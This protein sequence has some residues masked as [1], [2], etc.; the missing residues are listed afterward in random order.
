ME[1][2]MKKLDY[3][4]TNLSDYE[5]QNPLSTMVDFMDNNDLHHIREKVWQFYKGWVNNSVG[6]TEGDE[7]AD[8]LYFYTQ[9]VDFINAAFIYTEKRKLEIQPPKG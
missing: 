6:F 1:N 8:M 9:L 2:I 3:Q 5:L 7:N 4:P